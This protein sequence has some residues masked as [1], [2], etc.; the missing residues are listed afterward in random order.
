MSGPAQGL[1][2]S[3]QQLLLPIGLLHEVDCTVLHGLD[4]HR[5]ITMTTDKDDRNSGAHRVQL[6]LER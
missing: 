2:D 1:I 5:D 6:L 4:S 3:V